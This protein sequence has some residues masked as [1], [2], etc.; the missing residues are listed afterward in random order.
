MAVIA[1]L[2]KDGNFIKTIEKKDEK[3]EFEGQE[4]TYV[5][6]KDF[7]ASD[8][9]ASFDELIGKVKVVEGEEAPADE[10]ARPAAAKLT[11][12]YHLLKPLPPTADDHPK[13]PI[14]N[15]IEALNGGTVE[16]A[17][18]ACPKEN[19]KRKTSGVYTFNSEFRYFLK[20]GYAAMGPIPEGFDYT[21]VVKPVKE[22][23]AK[24]EPAAEATADAAQNETA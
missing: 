1:V 19:P 14:W 20:A 15:A 10:P 9:Y 18:E 13:K 4:V 22:K 17:M 24:A 21:T 7:Q 3:K 16:E 23:K 8:K 12:A 11:G 2:D 5:T 6:K